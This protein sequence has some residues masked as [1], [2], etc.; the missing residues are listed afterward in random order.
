MKNNCITLK[1]SKGKKHDYRI[2][3]DVEDS[4][5]KLNYILYTDE[6]KDSNGDVVCYASTYVLSAAGNITKLKPVSTEEEFNFLSKLLGS[7]ES[8]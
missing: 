3:I 6:S 1:D 2:L 7:L 5:N 8:E 4:E